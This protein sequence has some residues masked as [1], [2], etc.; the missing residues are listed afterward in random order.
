MKPIKVN[1]ISVNILSKK[2]NNF[3][4]GIIKNKKIWIYNIFRIMNLLILLPIFKI[5]GIA[6]TTSCYQ[7]LENLHFQFSELLFI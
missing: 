2:I 7:S 3:K 1:P 4:N 6:I 5:K